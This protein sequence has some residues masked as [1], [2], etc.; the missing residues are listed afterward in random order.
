MPVELDEALEQISEIRGHLATAET[1]RGYRAASVAGTG[2]LALLTAL[3]QPSVV[4]DPAANPWR[5]VGMWVAAAVLSA[6]GAGAQ[7]LHGYLK[8]GSPHRRATTRIVVGHLVPV[9]AAGALLTA[10]LMARDPA[11]AALLPGL[12]AILVGL[13]V[14]ASRRHL[15]RTIGWV[16][17]YYLLCGAAILGFLPGPEAMAPWVMGSTFGIGQ[18]A[19]AVVLYWNLERNGWQEEI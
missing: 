2:L 3:A 6:M 15:P 14:F 19:S 16:G 17:L 12:W 18:L 7:I 8:C 10:T 11:P 1:F 4:A 5:Y 9:V 13:G